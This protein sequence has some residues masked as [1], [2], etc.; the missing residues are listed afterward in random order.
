MTST[1]LVVEHNAPTR[2][3]ITHMLSTMKYAAVGVD[4]AEQAFRVLESVVI[5]VAVISLKLDDPDGADLAGELKARQQ[6]IKVVVVSGCEAPERLAPFVNAFVQ[7]PFS[8]QDID[9]AIKE[10]K[11]WDSVGRAT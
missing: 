1:I 10:V 5:D 11:A 3:T 9:E 4:N 2:E 6:D 8:L 7:K